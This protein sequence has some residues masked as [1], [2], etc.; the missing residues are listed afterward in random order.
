[1]LNKELAYQI[2][3]TVLQ[4]TEGYDTRVQVTSSDRGLTRFANSEI[5]QNVYEERTNVSITITQGKRR[6]S[7]NTD[8]YDAVGLQAAAQEAIANLSLLPEGEEQPP[9][10]E[11]PAALTAESFS[12]ALADQFDAE[13]RAR[14]I[15]E[16]LDMLTPEY[17]AFGA[18][19]Y[20]DSQ[21]AIGNSRGIRRLSAQNSVNF[22]ALV[23]DAAGGSGFG[24]SSGYQP[25]DLD[26]VGAFRTA[27][28]KA[29]LNKNPLDLEPGAYTVILEPLAVSSLLGYIA[30][31]FSGKRVQDKTSFLTDQ[32]GKQVFDEKLTIVD[33]HTD[34]HNL[35]LPFD[36]EGTPR[37]KV[38]L[39][40]NGVAKGLVYD[41]ASAQ[42][43]GVESTGHSVGWA[44]AGGRPRHLVVAPGEQTLAEI[45]KNTAD[46]LLVTRFH[47]INSVNS[48]AAILTGLTRDG[49][50]KIEDGEIVGAV[51][52]MRFTE[53]MLQAFNNIAAIS[54]ERYSIGNSYV[55]AMK[56]NNFHLTGKTHA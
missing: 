11:T 27:Y 33:D 20:S 3:D 5:H 41:L 38:T 10:V 46:G 45:I 35:S 7:V 30:G 29:R 50:F 49:V 17:K 54:S 25:E 24:R 12:Q 36:M 23:S 1:M 40:E 9:L 44:G 43:A 31:G 15:K 52:N 16:C 8:L 42:E 4:A 14:Y 21:L 53:S 2:I 51:H 37:Q 22:T 6:S 32:V 56:I 39:V 18:L 19:T 13:G 34:P 47:Y 48:R 28:E 26:V 55:P